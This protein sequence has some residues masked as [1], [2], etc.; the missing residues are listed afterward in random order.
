MKKQVTLYSS[1]AMLYPLWFYLSMPANW[2]FL[3]M[4]QFIIVSLVLFAGL[5]Y[6]GYDD[7]PSVWKKSILWNALY[8]FC[9]YL[10]TCGIFFATQ[11]LL[12][13]FPEETAA[14]DWLAT[15]LIDPLNSNPFSSI[16]CILFVIIVFLITGALVY[17]ANK[18]LAFRK[19]PLNDEQKHKVSLCLAIFAAP[20]LTIFPSYLLYMR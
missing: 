1:T 6:I 20:Y 18:K 3:A 16:V 8:G 11:F 2:I 19:A 12:I 10:I 17:V 4:T 9:S 5:K 14:G 15:K 7:V 13:A